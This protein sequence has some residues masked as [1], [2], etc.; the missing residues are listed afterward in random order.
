MPEREGRKERLENQSYA[1][2]VDGISK[3][4]NIAGNKVSKTGIS[5][6]DDIPVLLEL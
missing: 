4:T 6:L 2:Q 3:E 5:S 1:N